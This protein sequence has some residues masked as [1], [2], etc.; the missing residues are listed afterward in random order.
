MKNDQGGNSTLQRKVLDGREKEPNNTYEPNRKISPTTHIPSFRINRD[1]D[2]LTDE[3][4]NTINTTIRYVKY[5]MHL[6]YEFCNVTLVV[7]EKSNNNK[8]IYVL[9]ICHAKIGTYE[10]EILKY[11]TSNIY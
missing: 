4:Y 9:K 11:K 10:V 1:T 6:Y 5:V 2:T 3:G 7:T 8:N